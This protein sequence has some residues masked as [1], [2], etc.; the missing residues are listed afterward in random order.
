MGPGAIIEGD[1]YLIAGD[2]ASARDVVYGLHQL[3]P[4]SDIF[5]PIANV[6][7]P[8]ANAVVSGNAFQ[9][10]GWAFDDV[11]VASITV[12]VD[13]AL[14][15]NAVYGSSRPDVAT[16]WPHAPAQCGWTF[17][18]DSTQL[19]NGPHTITIHVADTSNNE[20]I[21]APVSVTV[22]N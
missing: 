14:K 3:L 20:A 2:Y 21:L 11:A 9:I 12:F 10:S 15:G 16:D 13:G 7:T 5:P 22:S 17:S 19:S 1:V 8:V 4:P 6:D 18:L